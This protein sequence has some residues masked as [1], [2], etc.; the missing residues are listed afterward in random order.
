M[1]IERRSVLKGLALGGAALALSQAGLGYAAQATAGS[2][3]QP[4]MVLVSGSDGQAAFV[5]GIKANPSV[6]Q[7][8]VLQAD[9][10]MDFISVFQ[11]RLSSTQGER[12]I[13]L[14][15]DAS[16]MLLLELAR[17]A[18]A[19]L[20]WTG[21]HVTQGG[22]SRHRVSSTSQ[23]ANCITQFAEHAHSCSRP[24]AMTEQRLSASRHWASSLG[25]ALASPEP[26]RRY[27]RTTP[28]THTPA[29]DGHF[30]SFSIE[31]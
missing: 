3:R 2:S 5:E 22:V 4:V 9:H 11:Q 19:K 6:A 25:F 31:T 1:S 15:D 29:V 27:L 18:G 30:V 10:G 12:I 28:P 21:Q 20:H 26:N 24:T 14:V 16:A 23:S 8:T 7:V 13:G 17:S